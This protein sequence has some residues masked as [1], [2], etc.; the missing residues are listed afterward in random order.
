MVTRRAI[1]PGITSIGMRKEI[2]ETITNRPD[3]DDEDEEDEDEDE[4]EDDEEETGMGRELLL[5]LT[6]R[7]MKRS[8]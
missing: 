1:R 5:F 6:N 4:D 7:S 2:Q 8:R 3:E